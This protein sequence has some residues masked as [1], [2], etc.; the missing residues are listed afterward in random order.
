MS[1]FLAPGLEKL[2]EYVPGEQPQDMQYIKCNTN[3]L[4]YPPPPALEERVRKEIARLR[5]YPDPESH[6]LR[7]SLAER[8]SVK[9]ENIFISNGSDE[10]LNFAF[11]CYGGDGI[12]FPDITYGFYSVFGDLHGISYEEMPLK[13]DWRVD[14]NDYTACGKTVVLANPNAPTG[15]CL[16]QEEITKIIESN[17]EHM[18]IIDEAYVDFGGESVVAL[19]KK[20][21]NLLVIGT[22]SK[23]RALAGAR[24]GFAVANPAVISDLNRIKNTTNPYNIN[25]LSMAAALAALENQAYF[26]EKIQEIIETRE[27]T[28]KAL[29]SLGFFVTDSKANFLFAGSNQIGGGELYLQLK[30]K[31][32]LVRH[33]SKD[34]I[35]NFIRI[36]VGT[37]EQMEILLTEIQS[38]LQET[39]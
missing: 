15:L 23:S 26:D 22:F 31:G 27:K 33:F 29:R 13:D 3:E 1:R 8:F 36:T 20:Y 9:E 6:T 34:R 30:K 38:I 2:E 7:Q 17:P 25:R 19:T 10:A 39:E 5:L 18:V 14:I 37:P 16:S 12:R 24:I 21:E 11:L 4:P 35:H 32:L 28:A